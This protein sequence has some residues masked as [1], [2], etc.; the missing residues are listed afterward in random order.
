M[1]RAAAAAGNSNFERKKILT[2][3][4]AVSLLN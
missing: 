3:E 4:W 1:V 2:P